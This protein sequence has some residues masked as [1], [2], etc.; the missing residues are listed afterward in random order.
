M[1]VQPDS[2]R[3]HFIG[4][5]GIGM[6]GIARILLARGRE[7]SGSDR[8]DSPT[9]ARL[10]A[11][12]AA[13]H[14]GSD[15]RSLPGAAAV[16]VSTAIR[17]S[18]P[19]LVEARRLGIPVLHRAAALASVMAGHRA[20]AVTGTAGKSSTTAMLVAAL[21]GAGVD[22]SYAIGADLDEP[23]SNGH[24][25]A[26]DL[27]IAEADES[28]GSFLR[29][30]VDLAVV[31]NIGIDHLDQHGS[32]EGYQQSFVAF[33][34]RIRPPGVLVVSADD[35]GTA[36]LAEVA[37]DRV[38]IVRTFGE[39]ASA[40]LRLADIAMAPDGTSY[41]ASVGDQRLPVRLPS[42]GRHNA[43][44]S[45]A[46]LLAALELG[47][48]AAGAVAG[49]ASF[50]GA[51]RRFE[52]KGTAGGV[53]VY[54]DYAHHPTKV[55]A[56]LQAARVVAGGGR[57]VVAF[58][59]HLYSRTQ[60]FAAEFGAALALADEVVVLDVYAAREDPVPGV[61]GALVA[62]AVPLGADHVRYEPDRSAVPGLLA[63]LA[64][65]GDLVITM[66]AGDVT[67][68]GPEVLERLGER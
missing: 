36:R 62:D 7:I 32:V 68:L 17:E 50:G 65:P 46:A 18:D 38:G 41:T 10:R 67:G 66:G 42:V 56:Q 4:I 25:G 34:D 26:D 12:G 29:L 37:R 43:H 63:S 6:S 11:L 44:N 33:L 48:A 24:E 40:D 39:S 57:L 54:D 8:A 27:F 35:P 59:P 9:V 60:A 28:D 53:R 61:T 23:G 21:R 52:L 55:A 1:S 22:P 47:A 51:R 31:T 64:R 19:E 15:P 13:V 14:V 3:T 16:V 5:G 45:A 49:L 30:S 2:G 20:V 58:Q